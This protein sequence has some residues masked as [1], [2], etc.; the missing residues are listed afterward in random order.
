MRI[1]QRQLNFA[2]AIIAVAFLFQSPQ[3]ALAARRREHGPVSKMLLRFAGDCY[4]ISNH[5]EPMAL[6]GVCK[7]RQ[8]TTACAFS[9]EYRQPRTASRIEDAWVRQ[10]QLSGG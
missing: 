4:P 10:W 1:Q 5:F 3:N 2:L 6:R 7:T 9:A 8:K